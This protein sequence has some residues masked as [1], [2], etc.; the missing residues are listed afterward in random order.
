MELK[1]ALT[2]IVSGD[3]ELEAFEQSLKS[4]TPYFQGLYVAVTNPNQEHKQIHKLVKKYKGVSMDVTPETHPE[5]YHEFN[6]TLKFANFA[7]ARNIVFDMVPDGYDYIAWADSDDILLGGE[8]IVKAA[9]VAKKMSL[10]AVFFTYWYACEFDE[11]GNVK[12]V[13]VHHNRE[14]LV[15]P[16][17]YRWVK[18]LHE[19]CDR[20]DSNYED[21]YGA[22]D[23]NPNEKRNC[24]WVHMSK[25]T[26]QIHNRNREI[27]ELQAEEEQYKDPRTIF[28]LAKTYFDLGA[29]D[30]AMDARCEE[31]LRKYVDMSGWDAEISNALEYLGMVQT[32]R[33]DF[34][35]AIET[36]HRAIREYPKHHSN[37]LRL[38]DLYFRTDRDDLA[39]HWLD[40][41][42]RM[43]VPA[44]DATISNP[45][46]IQVMSASLKATEAVKKDDVNAA[47]EWAQIRSKLLGDKDDDFLKNISYMRE[48]SF[49]VRGAYN[50]AK[51][52]KDKGEDQRLKD[53]IKTIPAELGQQ[54]LIQYWMTQ[55]REVFKWPENSVVY[56]AFT[57]FHE[58]TPDSLKTGIG[59]SETAVICLAREWAK[60]GY[61]VVVYG[62]CG[63]KGGM[64]EG[65][66]YRP[67]WQFNP[68]D[69]F[70]TLILW[71]NPPMVDMVH[72]VK[73]LY[74]DL[75]DIAS[76]Y[77]WPEIRW[78]KVKKIFVKSKY[79]RNNLPNIP[80]DKFV[81]ISNGIHHE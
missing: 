32:R 48:M 46:E 21:K 18:R 34:R 56:Y 27:L 3:N 40:V 20:A 67:A 4:F 80:D 11:K 59:G 62:D 45:Y 68:N 5:V 16:K 69:E 50:Y 66:E 78:S 55:T 42:M 76:T 30:P 31:L 24:V 81:I 57:G 79:H 39:S 1:L 53:L 77:H 8:E 43:P 38:A 36:F 73:N 25:R 7:A 28:Y 9:S 19:V 61:Q 41:A 54:P 23:Y 47:Y 52:L 33:G 37:Y 63:D 6:G 2:Y 74:V 75:H 17:V 10:D 65:V 51:W 49:A 29:E 44:S 22:W 70:N 71:R 72:S 35:G 14:R 60:K 12:Q 58:W 64:Y 13:L 15:K 26:N